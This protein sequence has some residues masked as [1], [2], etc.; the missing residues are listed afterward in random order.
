MA[1]RFEAVYGDLEAEDC[2][3]AEAKAYP[4]RAR[5]V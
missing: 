4:K 5:R 1:Q 3:A 2:S